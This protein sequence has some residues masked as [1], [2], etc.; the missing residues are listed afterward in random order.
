[1]C[2]GYSTIRKVPVIK[3]ILSPAE[4]L[5]GGL[6]AGTILVLA[7]HKHYRE[8]SYMLELREQNTFKES[9]KKYGVN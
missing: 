9:E 7:M 5:M 2:N 4:Y 8:E 3:Q 1:M 6:A